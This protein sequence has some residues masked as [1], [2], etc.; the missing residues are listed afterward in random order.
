[1]DI[2]SQLDRVIIEPI[3]EPAAADTQP[4][5]SR[6]AW[7]P[8]ER[9]HGSQQPRLGYESNNG[10]NAPDSEAVSQLADRV[11]AAECDPVSPSG[12]LGRQKLRRAIETVAV[13]VIGER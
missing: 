10:Q 9:A 13:E 8:R 5:S 4:V 7:P 2:G 3:E 12:L 6:E 1:M 11:S